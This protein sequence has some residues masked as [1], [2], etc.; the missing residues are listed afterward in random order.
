M[1][2]LNAELGFTEQ[3]RESVSPWFNTSGSGEL[4]VIVG[5]SSGGGS[6]WSKEQ[7]ISRFTTNR[8]GTL[9]QTQV[10]RIH[11]CTD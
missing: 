2:E 9:E 10:K 6:R 11:M 5:F 1:I 4:G 7:Y 8:L 3:V